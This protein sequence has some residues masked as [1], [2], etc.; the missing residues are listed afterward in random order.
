MKWDWNWRTALTYRDR[1]KDKTFHRKWMYFDSNDAIRFV[2]QS[3]QATNYSSLGS[4]ECE[5][6]T[7]AF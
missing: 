7:C 1:E 4:K 5:L 2:L 3:W 6:F